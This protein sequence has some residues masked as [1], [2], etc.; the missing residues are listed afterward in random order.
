MPRPTALDNISLY[1]QYL[2]ER[3]DDKILENDKGFITWRYLND[4]QIYIVD[5]FVKKEFRKDKI[6]TIFAD[7]VCDMAK[8]MGYVEVLGTVN[9]SAKGADDSL[10]VLWGYGMKLDKCEPNIIIMKKDI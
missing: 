6:A 10:R 2:Q 8:K 7:S 4:K 5:I 3:T 1:A 9:P